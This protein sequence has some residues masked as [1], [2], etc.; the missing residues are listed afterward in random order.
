[1]YPYGFPKL[2]FIHLPYLCVAFLLPP[3]IDT[4]SHFSHFPLHS[5]WVLA[6]PLSRVQQEFS[7]NG[8]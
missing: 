5:S 3:W 6:P 1:M 4:P 7:L 2:S 8:L